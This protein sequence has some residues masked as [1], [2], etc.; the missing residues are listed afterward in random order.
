MAS[1]THEGRDK[2]ASTE[3]CERMECV[4]PFPALHLVMARGH[5]EISHSASI[6]SMD[7]GTHYKQEDLCCQILVE[8]M[9][10]LQNSQLTGSMNGL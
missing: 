10:E 8:L 3:P 1:L 6:Y 5:L 7:I 2:L 9:L 4:H